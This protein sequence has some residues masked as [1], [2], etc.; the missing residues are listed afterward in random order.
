MQG[1]LLSAAGRMLA[2]TRTGQM[3]ITLVASLLAGNVLR[4]RQWEAELLSFHQRSQGE[5]SKE[6]K[7]EVLR[8]WK[9]LVV[10]KAWLLA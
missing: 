9:S 6:R 8:W 4:P 5:K 10:G 1:T 7:G 2:A 3:P